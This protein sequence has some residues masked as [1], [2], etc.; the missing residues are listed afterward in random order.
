MQAFAIEFSPGQL[1]PVRITD[2]IVAELHPFPHVPLGTDPDKKGERVPLTGRLAATRTPE[3]L[4]ARAGVFRDPKTGRIVLGME[5]T[6]GEDPRALVL[7]T[8]ANSFPEGVAVS[9]GTGVSVLARGEIRNGEQVLLIWPENGAVVIQDPVREE[10]H[11]L[12]RTGTQFDRV[13]IPAEEV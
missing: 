5:Q 6:N 12:R 4:I 10:R 11:E 1:N 3:Q 9:P 7:L 8:A 2:A 13:L